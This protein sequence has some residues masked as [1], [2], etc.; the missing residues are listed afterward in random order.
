[1]YDS[2]HNFIKYSVFH[3]N[4]LSSFDSK[5]DTVNQF[6]KIFKKLEGVK[7]QNNERRQ[8]K[9]TVVKN[10]SFLHDQ[11]I[12][13]Y[14]KE[15]DQAFK[16]KDEGWRQKNDYKNLKYLDYHRYQLQQDE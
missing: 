1:M 3:F 5:F 16:S 15:Y 4:K 11:L 2:V 14:K 6:Q 9:I 10:A 13:F 8:K 7:S 12:N